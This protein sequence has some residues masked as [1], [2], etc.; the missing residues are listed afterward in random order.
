MQLRFS[1]GIWVF[2]AGI[3]RF[4]P[5]GYKSAKPIVDLIKDASKVDGL[6]GLEFHYPTEVN[7]ENVKDV[8]NTLSVYNFKAVGIAVCSLVFIPITS[9]LFIVASRAST[10]LHR[11]QAITVGSWA[12]VKVNGTHLPSTGSS[13]GLEHCSHHPSELYKH[14]QNQ[15]L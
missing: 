11:S 13:R 14:K 2:G 12:A 15:S 1:T 10:S 5:M 7:E 8:K 9:F 6:T 4:A 3:E